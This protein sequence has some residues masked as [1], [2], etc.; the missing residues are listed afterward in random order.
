MD[1]RDKPDHDNEI[2]SINARKC[3]RWCGSAAAQFPVDCSLSVSGAVLRLPA[4]A[5]SKIQVNVER[6]SA[7]LLD[8]NGRQ[9]FDRLEVARIG[10]LHRVRGQ[11]ATDDQ[12]AG[13]LLQERS[14]PQRI[15]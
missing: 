8:R 11:T 7:R 4:K 9:L 14:W 10:A 5:A 2:D 15:A 12:H 13:A 6:R 1:G 3:F